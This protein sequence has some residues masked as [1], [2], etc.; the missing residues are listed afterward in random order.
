MSR[1]AL[2]LIIVV[3]VLLVGG[4]TFWYFVLRTPTDSTLIPTNNGGLPFGQGGGDITPGISGSQTPN[5]TNGGVNR[6]TAN[7]FKLTDVPVSGATSLLKNGFTVVRYIERSTG[8]IYDINPVTLEK[9]RVTNN[10]VPKIYESAFN[11]DASRALVRSLKNNSDTVENTVLTLTPPTASS[12]DELHTVSLSTLRGSIGEI[13]VGT[14]NT[15]AYTTNDTGAIYTASFLGEKPSQIFSSPFRGWLISWKDLGSL[16]VVSKASASVEG[17]A[18][19]LNTKTAAFTKLLGPLM[20]LTLT[21]SA[22]GKHIVYSYK[23]GGRNIL[24]AENLTS[25]LISEITPTTLAEKCVWSRTTSSVLYCG[26]PTG[27]VGP[28]EPDNWY[29]GS[30]HFSDRVW[31]FNTDTGFTDVLVD[32]KKDF[33]V[34]IDTIHPI[35]TGDEDYLILQNKTDLSLWALKL[36]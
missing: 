9:T 23:D 25:D 1:K 5:S 4:A 14:D 3:L 31:R 6:P 24:R 13:A 20:A 33:N 12:T 34:D 2:A 36:I 21:G 27:G 19:T 8:H 7:F 18:Y 15:L 26:A 10:T 32:P 22:D 11:K 16:F 28:G 35:L 29:Q 17:Y 30:T